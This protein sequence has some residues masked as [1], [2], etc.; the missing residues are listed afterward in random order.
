LRVFGIKLKSDIEADLCDS[1][2][3]GTRGGGID[4]MGFI[5]AIK[6]ELG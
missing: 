6:E 5:K 4:Y 1:L 3:E 2:T